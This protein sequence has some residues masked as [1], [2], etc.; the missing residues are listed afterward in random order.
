MAGRAERAE[1]AHKL[2]S[3]GMNAAG[4]NMEFTQPLFLNPFVW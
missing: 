3:M 4:Q 1:A 2:Y